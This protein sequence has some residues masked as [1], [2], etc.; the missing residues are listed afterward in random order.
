LDRLAP[1]CPTCR[2]LGRPGAQLTLGTIARSHDD[3]VLE[4]ALLCPEPLCQREHPI[5]D[6]IPVV[7]ADLQSW[8]LHQFDAVMRREDLSPFTESL[9]GD[10]AGPGSAFD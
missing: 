2:S 6:G 9:L 7:V 5:I 10:A 8:A 4:G 3:D 1:V